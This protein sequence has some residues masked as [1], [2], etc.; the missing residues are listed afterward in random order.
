MARKVRIF[1]KDSPQHVIL[2]GLDKLT[3]FKDES[4]YRAFADILRE[5]SANSDL[6]LH[7]YV[8]MP[9][10]FEFLAT[11]SNEDALSKFMQSLGRKYVGYFNKKYNRTGTIFEG[12]YKSS[13]VEDE[14]YLFDVML[15]IEKLAP[16]EHLFSSV[17]KNLYGKKDEILSY[18]SLYKKLGFTDEQR[19]QRYGELFNSAI[20][21]D[22]DD[23][24]TT[25]LEKQSVTGSED[26][27]KNLE[28]IVGFSLTLKA[29]GRPKKE[30][31]K[32][33]KKMY[34]NLV[35]LDKEKHKELK[36][37]PLED[38]FFAKSAAHIPLLANEVAQVGSA[39]PVVFTAGE[40]PELTAIVSLGTESLAINE[41]GKWI[42]SY[43][44]SYLRKYPF[45]LASTKE[46]PDQKVI[47]I[48]EDSSLFSKSKGKQLFK[49]NSE[50]S[51]TLDHAINFLTSYDNQMSV[52]LNVAKLIAK[53]GILE[54]REISV[55]EG[56]EKKVLVNGFKVVNREKLN[57][58]SDD[59]LADWVRKGIM[60]MIEA[61]LKSLDNIQ[62]LFEI[63][64]KRQS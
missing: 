15:Y 42:T 30:Q 40:V 50:K 55:G 20:N 2:R 24:I 32:K 19:V 43:V 33:G 53:S 35:I 62:T 63:A 48:D 9:H 27:V 6:A 18:H 14:K 29:R 1:V 46:N 23:F 41:A 16:K 52:T 38:L 25:C 60:A 34:K 61:H 12:R 59:I 49:K 3:I 45:S 54:N 10:F 36:I 13:L 44:P 37:N 47:L 26:F 5:S 51:E 57:A 17:H 7:A 11:P 28:K 4:D 64:Q 56:E 8:L 39:F 22:K 31:I 21:Y 58:L